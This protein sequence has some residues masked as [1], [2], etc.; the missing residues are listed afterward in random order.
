MTPGPAPASETHE[1]IGWRAADYCQRRRFGG[2]S[3]TDQ[4]ELDAWLAEA[5]SHRV[6][7]LRVEWSVA[8]TEQLAGLRPGP[9]SNQTA[10]D[11]N[12]GIMR[13]RFV[14]PF[15][16]IAASLGFIAMLGL[17]AET[18]FLKPADR[19]YSTDT[20]GRAILKFAGGTQIELNTDTVVRFRMTGEERTVWLEKGEAWFH[21]S[22]DAS[23]PF[24][25][26][27]GKHRVTD[28]GTEF[29]VRRD[30]DGMEVTLLKGRAS[31][32]TEGAQTAML[33]PGDDAV[34]GLASMSITRKTPQELA[35]ELAW[36]RGVLVFRNTPLADAVREFNRYNATKLVINDPAVAKMTLGGEFETDNLDHFLSLAQAVLNL[37]VEQQGH[38]I[39]LSREAGETNR[40]AR[41][42]RSH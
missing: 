42:K 13:R 11:S 35:D 22:H 41:R 26:I 23:R 33:S 40:S 21:A 31:L 36:R 7:F 39:L 3:K 20:G 1:A 29:L 6:A 24:N 30:P 2:W 5:A 10:P 18:Y 38:D 8:R 4:A 25:V 27:V 19:T 28:L 9:K 15:L 17:A 14:L 37:H 12:G 32:S 16:A 34:A